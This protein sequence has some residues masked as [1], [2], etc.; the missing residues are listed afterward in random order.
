M[1]SEKNFNAEFWK[2]VVDVSLTGIYVCDYELNLVYVNK[3]VEIATGYK[4]DELIGRSVLNLLLDEDIEMQK[5]QH[6][7]VFEGETISYETRY[8]R[9]DGKVR[10]VKGFVT[11]VN[12][13]GEVYALGNWIDI[14]KQKKLEEKLKEDSELFKA[15]VHDSPTPAYVISDDRKFIYVNN[16]LQE[17]VGYSWDELRSMDPLQFVHPE[18][19]NVVERRYKERLAGKRKPETYSWRIISRDGSVHWITARP[20]RITFEGKP[21]VASILIDTTDLHLLADE[22]KKSGEYLTL[23]NKILR[24]DIL[25]D[26]TVIRGYIE[27]GRDELRE[28]AI[29][30]IEK[31]QTLIKETK[32]IE[33]ALGGKHRINL[34][35]IVTEI[36]KHYEDQ[37]DIEYILNDVFVKAN[38]ALNSVIDNILRNAVMHSK[39][40]RVKISIEVFSSG[41]F[42]VVRIKDNGIGIPDSIKDQIFEEGFSTSNSTGLGLYIAKKV[43]ELLNGEIHVY[44]NEPSGAVFEIKLRKK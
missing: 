43:I 7:R 19:K 6:K 21:A 5:K 42:G 29:S 16:A 38:E 2:T 39:K 20:A 40:D 35:E 37:A 13:N 10:W 30:K 14:T 1:L 15:L 27:M 24:H 25:N 28:V 33:E 18:D 11:P 23:V 31:I 3:I 26:L 41:R 17:L 22:L 9:K 8:R 12:F 44:D 32:A 34:A 4:K 36:G